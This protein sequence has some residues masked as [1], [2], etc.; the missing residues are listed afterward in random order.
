MVVRSGVLG[1]CF[2]CL[3]PR[4]FDKFFLVQ[5]L[6]YIIDKEILGGMV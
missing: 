2:F 1:H 3:M 5:G 6:Y 4:G